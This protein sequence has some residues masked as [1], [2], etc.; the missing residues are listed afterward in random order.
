[1]N[2]NYTDWLVSAV[3]SRIGTDQTLNGTRISP[4]FHGSEGLHRNARPS[5]TAASPARRHLSQTPLAFVEQPNGL[6]D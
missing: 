2:A 6:R 4:G 1:M 3:A 5:W